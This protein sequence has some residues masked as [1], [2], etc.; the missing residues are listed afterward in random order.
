MVTTELFRF[1][2]LRAPEQVDASRTVSL[3]YAGETLLMAEL[4]QAANGPWPQADMGRIAQLFV[5][6]NAGFVRSADSLNY[7]AKLSQIA[8]QLQNLPVGKTA[9][10]SVPTLL[11]G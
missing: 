8:D 6:Q 7:G 5:S 3:D 2:V 1:M 4:T 9:Q 11:C 10:I